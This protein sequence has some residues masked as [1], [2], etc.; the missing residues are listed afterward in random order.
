[1]VLYAFILRFFNVFHHF[2]MKKS[3]K[4]KSKVEKLFV[5]LLVMAEF[6]CVLVTADFVLA[7]I[8]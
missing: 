7:K 2:L 5:T 1:M 3:E 8:L 6:E 4:N